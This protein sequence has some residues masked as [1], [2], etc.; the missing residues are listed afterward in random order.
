M[1]F[2]LQRD[3][4]VGGTSGHFISFKKGVPT[5]VP[6]SMWSDVQAVGAVPQ[7]ELPEEEVV[8]QTVVMDASE[9]EAAYFAAFDTL[10][11]RN[12]RGD[13]TASGLPNSKIL[14]KFL[15]F[16]VVN[17]ERDIMWEKYNAAK[18]GDE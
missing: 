18:R 11:D 16:T 7:G 6:K 4:V 13:F 14:E 5:Y 8:T 12:E 17:K 3:K 2:V 1:L 9:R 15:N 10:I